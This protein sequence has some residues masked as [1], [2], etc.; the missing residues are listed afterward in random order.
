MTHLP[1]ANGL[2]WL[3]LAFEFPLEGVA[4]TDNL[5]DRSC[6]TRRKH[7]SC[8]CGVILRFTTLL[9]KNLD[10]TICLEAQTL[11]VL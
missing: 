4:A 9:W 1:S 6:G 11:L 10:V 8:H 7:D 2:S 3:C 5:K